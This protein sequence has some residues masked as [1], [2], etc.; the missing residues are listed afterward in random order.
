MA[1]GP[2]DRFD[3]AY[4]QRYYLDPR[5]CVTSRHQMKMRAR[6]IAAQAGYLGLPVRTILDA[7]CGV[8][9]L[10]APL[11]RSL[12]GASYTGLEFSA[13][14]CTRYGWIQGSIETYSPQRPFD[15]VVCYD[16]LQYLDA[17]SAARA[18]SNLG[19]VC[20]G[21]L[22]ISALTLADWRD[23]CDQSRTDSDVHL[24]A[25]E[26]YRRRL[27]RAFREIGAGFWLHRDLDVAVWEMEG[28]GIR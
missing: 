17:R 5:T 1:D 20:Q 25:G 14:L 10:R 11:R 23:N 3:R 12:P 13:Y 27:R 28:A 4:Y 24:R 7:G 15:L 2:A 16:V 9:M 21:L 22:Y 8:G 26:W 6:L 18:L 19:S